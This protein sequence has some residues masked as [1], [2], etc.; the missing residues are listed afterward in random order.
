MKALQ[1]SIYKGM[2]GKW[3]AL[4]LNFQEP[5]YYTANKERDHNGSK[6]LDEDGKLR[7]GWR[8]REGAIFLEITSATGKNIYDW[9]HKIV[10]ALSVTDM[11]K[12]ALALTTGDGCKILHDPNA[13]TESQGSVTKSLSV[14]S[15]QGTKA[16]AIVEVSMTSGGQT[17]K[18]TVPLTGDE[19]L[20]VS[21]LVRTAISRSLNW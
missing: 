8:I 16:G 17:T 21:Q 10:M 13:K 11:G 20:V 1:H 9:E 7:E 19:L 5:H 12:V 4:Q 14:S 15:P 3:G 18:H 6:A 2:A